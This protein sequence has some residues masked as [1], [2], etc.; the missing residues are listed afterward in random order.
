MAGR[1]PQPFKQRQ[2]STLFVR[3]PRAEWAA[4]R[5][6]GKREFRAASGKHSALFNVPT[7][8][9]VVAYTIDSFSRYSSAL[10]VLEKVWREPLGAISEESLAAE[11]FATFAHFRR[12]WVIREKRYFPP[13]RM[14]T[15]YRVRPWTPDDDREMAEVLLERLYGDFLSVS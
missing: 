11:G 14:T 7:P 3:V 12:A 9:P 5:Y 2:A 15:A 8:T 10:M 1:G 4:V 6:G 13:L